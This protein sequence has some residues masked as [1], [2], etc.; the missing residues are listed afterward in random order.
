MDCLKIIFVYMGLIIGAGFASGRE[1][2]EYFNF[3]SNTDYTGI[4]IAALL[5]AFICYAILQ[6][7]YKYELYSISDYI[8]HIFS[9]SKILKNIFSVLIFADLCC[10][11]IV[12]L[13]SCGEMFREY[14]S[15]PKLSGSIILALMCFIV[16]I[17][18]IK[19]IE[20]INFLLVPIITV[21]ITV[22]CLHSIFSIIYSETFFLTDYFMRSDRNM[23]LL[24]VC[25]VSYNTLTA[26][27]V[28]SPLSRN[29]KEKKTIL[30]SS[31]IGGLIIGLLIFAV[32]YAVSLNFD[33]LWY[34]TFPLGKLSTFIDDNFRYI[35]FSC[36]I[37]SIFTTA[38][39]EGYGII[40]YFNINTKFKRII[41]SLLMFSAAIP[42]STIDFA[43]LVRHMYFIMGFLGM[44]WILVILIDYLKNLKA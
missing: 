40:S 29:I 34:E 7:S 2:C 33:T 24:S 16:F 14:L 27:S 12:M 43:Y 41:T 4:V 38:V 9:F 10:G 1:I 18:D 23:L 44:F 3:C 28:L 5:F 15:V 22:I 13:S 6:K 20:I 39:S 21:I 36:L 8:G 35:Y 37:M 17:F 19:G 32:W 11:L 30:I 26:A 25:Y 42:L 31:A